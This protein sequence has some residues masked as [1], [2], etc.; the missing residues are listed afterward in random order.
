MAGKCWR[1]LLLIAALGGTVWLGKSRAE[2]AV[3]DSPPPPEPGYRIVEEVRYKAVPCNKHVCPVQTTKKISRPVY[4]VKCVD[5]AL[6]KCP[7]CGYEHKC[8][9]SCD[10][11]NPDCV[12]CGKIRTKK[13]LLKKFVTE[14]C[15]TT[16]CEVQCDY[17]QVPYTV[18]RKVPIGGP[19]VRPELI[20][21]PGTKPEKLAPPKEE[22]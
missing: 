12:K 20:P 11:G 4:D 15:P 6:K 10:G 18:Y 19:G 22:K 3:Y 1:L 16:K 5:F 17:E 8:C 2:E 7:P 9:T 21:A 14:E 13:I